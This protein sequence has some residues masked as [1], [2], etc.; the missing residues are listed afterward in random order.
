M[1]EFISTVSVN[2]TYFAI[3]GYGKVMQIAQAAVTFVDPTWS[4]G[5]VKPSD[6]QLWYQDENG[7]RAK[8][9]GY[10]LYSTGDGITFDL[11]FILK[12]LM[13]FQLRFPNIRRSIPNR[14]VR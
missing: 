3:H 1:N 6:N 10:C 2:P 5:R 14:Q 8:T 11:S 13:H 12:H 4:A 9:N 7:I